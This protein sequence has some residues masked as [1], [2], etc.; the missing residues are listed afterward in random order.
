MDEVR[1]SH[2]DLK[3][4]IAGLYQQI[5][6]QKNKQIK[7][8]KAKLED[9]KKQ[10]QLS[11]TTSTILTKTTGIQEQMKLLLE[12]VDRQSLKDRE[13]MELRSKLAHAEKSLVNRDNELQL[14]T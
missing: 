3:E 6:E 8:L 7:T 14:A 9:Q 5:I 10:S 13:I 11:E 2:K 1:Q 4:E 12:C